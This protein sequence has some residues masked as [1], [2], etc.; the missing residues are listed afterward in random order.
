MEDRH[1]STISGPI[2]DAERSYAI[3]IL[4]TTRDTLRTALAG[5][6]LDQ[7]QY[8]PAPDRWSIT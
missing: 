2:T 5:L 7:Q 4:M 8:K 3:D 1:P 6:S